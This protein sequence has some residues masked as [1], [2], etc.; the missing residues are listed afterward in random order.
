MPIARSTEKSSPQAISPYNVGISK[1][2]EVI[3]EVMESGPAVIARKV[4]TMLKLYVSANPIAC[5]TKSQVKCRFPPLVIT[6]KSNATNAEI[7]ENV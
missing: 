2:Y 3:K 5:G 4:K 1:E 7:A 6:K